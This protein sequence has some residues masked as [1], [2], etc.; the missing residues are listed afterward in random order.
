MSL[1]YYIHSVPRILSVRNLQCRTDIVGGELLPAMERSAGM[2][3]LCLSARWAC[4]GQGF[5]GIGRFSDRA[6]KNWSFVV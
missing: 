4:F 2:G 3:R 6:R 5:R 1:K